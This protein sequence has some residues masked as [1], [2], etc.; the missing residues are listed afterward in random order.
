MKLNYAACEKAAEGRAMRQTHEES[1]ATLK[2]LM[3]AAPINPEVYASIIRGK[4]RA[5][6]LIEDFRDAAKQ[7][8][9]DIHWALT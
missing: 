8:R 6:R 1:T 4:V 3:T 9:E 7:S 2:E 5:R